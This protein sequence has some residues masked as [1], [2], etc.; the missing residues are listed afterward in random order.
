MYHKYE[1]VL[2]FNMSMSSYPAVAPKV[3]RQERGERRV[4]ELLEAAEAV[5]AESGYEAATMSAI[6]E[7]AGAAIGHVAKS[8]GILSSRMTARR[9][10]RGCVAGS[11]SSAVALRQRQ[12]KC[13]P[14]LPDLRA[15]SG[16]ECAD[17]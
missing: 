4:A 13:A 15:G 8:G 3:P 12:M 1:H 10:L 17:R 9:V 16:I 14:P 5:I 11:R 7:R 2:T 6:A